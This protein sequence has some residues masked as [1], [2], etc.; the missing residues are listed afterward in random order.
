[1]SGKTVNSAIFLL[2]L[3][4]GMA[5]V[6]DMIVKMQ[7]EN[8]AVFQFVAVRLVIMLMLLLPFIKKVNFDRLWEGGRLQFIRAHVSYAGICCMVVALSTL[9]LATANAIFYAAPLLVVVF[10]V[11]FFR[12]TLSKSSLFAV[13]SGFIGI[14]VILRPLEISWS[15]ISAIG[16]ACS[17][18]ISATL[19]RK[20]PKGQSTVH[21]ML[22]SQIMMVPIA[23][24]LAIWE[25]A[26]FDTDTLY[27]AL[28]SAVFISMYNATVFMSYKW[29]SPQQ[30]TSAEY[31]GM[32]WAILLGVMF[33]DEVP[34]AW[35]IV[36]SSLIIL[37][38]L[39]IAYLERKR[40]LVGR[41][42][43]S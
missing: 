25:D 10:S 29:V 20:L 33:F 11:L 34:D 7:G 8:V 37:P 30:V 12:E 38:L 17:L 4:N 42:A 18:A 2:I 13:V 1:M 19:V 32:I 40:K 28:G 14:L 36:G 35:L 39:G 22:V 26:P 16:V 5:M 9:P 27:Y 3:G 31:T 23:M 24:A 21:S 15:A 41:L 43:A 6:S